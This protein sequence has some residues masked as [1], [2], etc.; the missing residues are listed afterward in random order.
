VTV[1][2]LD[3][4]RK[5]QLDTAWRDGPAIVVAKLE[6]G[7]TTALSEQLGS[8]VTIECGDEPLRFLDPQHKLK[9]E[10]SADAVKS[11]ATIDFDDKL[12]PTGWHLAPPL[13]GRAKLEDLLTPAV[14]EKTTP[15]V[16][17]DCGPAAFLVR[18]ADG[19]VWCSV[20]DA[21]KRAKLK[22]EVDEKLVVHRW[23]VV[24]PPG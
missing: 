22:V 5:L 8:P 13:L 12:E 24:A 14:R 16:K 9:C 4:N 15:T 10:L 1:K 18:P 6:P 11:T 20:S 21:G 2:D 19:W 3:K 23:E 7:L 17:I